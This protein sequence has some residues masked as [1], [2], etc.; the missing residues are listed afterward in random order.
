MSLLEALVSV[1]TPSSSWIQDSFYSLH[2]VSGALREALI[3]ENQPLD[4]GKVLGV[5]V[6]FVFV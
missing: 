3:C 5:Q 4:I 6:P 1:P 2:D